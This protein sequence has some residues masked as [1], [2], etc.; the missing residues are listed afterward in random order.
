MPVLIE[1]DILPLL[2][3]I[4]RQRFPSVLQLRVGAGAITH[5]QNAADL[6]LYLIEAQLPLCHIPNKENETHR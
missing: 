1:P 4:K 5:K 6:L 3:L 2:R